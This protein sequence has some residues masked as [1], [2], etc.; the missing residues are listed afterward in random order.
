MLILI[1]ILKI[2]KKKWKRNLGSTHVHGAR[3]VVTKYCST[4]QEPTWFLLCNYL[5]IVIKVICRYGCLRPYATHFEHWSL[6][7]TIQSIKRPR[8]LLAG[9]MHYINIRMCTTLACIK[10]PFNG[11]RGRVL[12]GAYRD[13]VQ[14]ILHNEGIAASG[15]PFCP[16]ASIICQ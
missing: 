14:Q 2:L 6:I 15:R 13:R 12:T 3:L 7:S 10:Q 1:P 16:K 8:F 11:R 5:P 9:A 4:Y